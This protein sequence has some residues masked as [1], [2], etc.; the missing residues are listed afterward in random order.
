MRRVLLFVS[1]AVLILAACQAELD[2]IPEIQEK[3][4]ITTGY[5][6]G[7]S[8]M[9]NDSTVFTYDGNKVVRADAYDT[10]VTY[11]YTGN[12]L[13]GRKFYYNPNSELYQIDTI[14]YDANNKISRVVSWYYDDPLWFDTSRVVLKFEYSGQTL[15]RVIE[16]AQ[17][18]TPLGVEEDTIVNWM[19]SNA[20]GNIEKM[21]LADMD[22]Y[23]W[24]S[25]AYEYDNSPNYFSVAHPNFF[26]F[27]PYFMLHAGLTPHFPYFYSKNNVTRFFIDGNFEYN[28]SYG[29]DTANRLTAID[30]DGMEYMKY[31]YACQ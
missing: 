30:M 3:C 4:K 14:H 28:I 9:M 23:R 19:Y 6:Y 16:E 21:V 5:Y 18:F 25:I 22:G 26:L 20:A 31:K 27:D 1:S 10:Y 17:V 24:D 15:Q 7:G 12:N 2:E 8:G 11:T 29:L 13:T